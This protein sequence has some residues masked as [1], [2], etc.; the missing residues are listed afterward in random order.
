MREKREESQ[1]VGQEKNR[2]LIVVAGGSALTLAF[3]AAVDGA[4]LILDYAV[5]RGS[6]LWRDRDLRGRRRWR[7]HHFR[8][9]G[10]GTVDHEVAFRVFGLRARQRPLRCVHA[11]RWP[12]REA[13]GLD[14]TRLYAAALADAQRVRGELSRITEDGDAATLSQIAASATARFNEEGALAARADVAC[15]QRQRCRDADAAKPPPSDGWLKPCPATACAAN[16][17]PLRSALTP[18]RPRLPGW[19][20]AWRSYQGWMLEACQ[21]CL[22]WRLQFYLCLWVKRLVLCQLRPC[23]CCSQPWRVVE[24]GAS[25]P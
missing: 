13:H 19:R 1:G 4:W 23:G 17:P 2:L 20:W 14:R 3:I 6:P 21:G 22:Y 5:G 25:S 12:G 16:W 18:V 9:R 24:S 11:R 10:R 7:I 15:S 8:A